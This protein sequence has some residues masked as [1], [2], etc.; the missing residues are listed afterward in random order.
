MEATIAH[1]FPQSCYLS[2]M[3]LL[4]LR[5]TMLLNLKG[6]E[7]SDDDIVAASREQQPQLDRMRAIT[8]RGCTMFQC[9][10]N[11]RFRVLGGLM[12]GQYGERIRKGGSVLA[13]LLPEAKKER[14]GQ[15]G[16]NVVAI[17]NPSRK[18]P[19]LIFSFTRAD[20][21]QRVVCEIGACRLLTNDG[22]EKFTSFEQLERKIEDAICALA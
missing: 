21:T 11:F 5:E 10:L 17:Q 20:R 22:E 9:P 18:N 15:S 14:L 6:K 7:M 8:C 3:T 16:I 4:L 1:A 19:Q 12:N 2:G 13:R